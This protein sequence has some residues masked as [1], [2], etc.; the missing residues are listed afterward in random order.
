MKVRATLRLRNEAAMNAR[1]AIGMSQAEVAK[2]CGVSVRAVCYVECLKF[3]R[4]K[5]DNLVKIADFL[6]I[7]LEDLA[8][9][10]LR[11]KVVGNT[12]SVSREMSSSV[13]LSFEQ[14]LM[15][16][17]KDAPM[18]SAEMKDAI[19]KALDTLCFREREVV[20]LRFGIGGEEPMTLSELSK[21]F[22]I[23]PENVRRIEN[24]AIKKLQH[25]VRAKKL[26]LIMDGE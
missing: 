16:E 26:R 8:P 10:D 23:S 13:L 25:P 21:I 6:Q 19:E 5:L 12:Y 14:P 1:E 4:V 3:G 18:A 20:K 17:D 11:K 15:L 24:K 7:K 2:A 9:A 22:R